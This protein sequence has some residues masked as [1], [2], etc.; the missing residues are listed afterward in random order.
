MVE[1]DII[2]PEFDEHRPSPTMPSRQH[3]NFLSD[4][5]TD[6]EG[7]PKKKKLKKR[8]KPKEGQP[9]KKKLKKRLKPKARESEPQGPLMVSTSSCLTEPDQVVPEETRIER[10]R[11]EEEGVVFDRI[12]PLPSWDD[13]N[14]HELPTDRP[15]QSRASCLTNIASEDGNIKRDEAEKLSDR[16]QQSR[17]SC[18]TNITAEDE[19]LSDRPQQSRASCLTNIASEALVELGIYETRTG[20]T[21]DDAALD[22]RRS[23]RLAAA[24]SDAEALVDL[25]IYE[26]RT[27]PTEDVE[28]NRPQ[29]PFMVSTSSCFTE[30]EQVV[31]EATRSNETPEDVKALVDLGVYETRDANAHEEPGWEMD[32][33]RNEAEMI[34]P[35]PR[36]SK[37]P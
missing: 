14:L 3:V 27:G 15:Q 1:I 26:S 37:K 23:Q 8:L 13:D 9:T 4:S 33:I 28:P 34:E 5:E 19:K 16:P 32:M 6:E 22:N 10:S 25:G 2:E 12:P 11:L 30:P 29:G 31:P 7:Q 35:Q 36:D 18:L 21:Q 24:P 17:A 20:T